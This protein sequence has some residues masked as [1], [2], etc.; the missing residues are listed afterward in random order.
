MSEKGRRLRACNRTAVEVSPVLRIAR[1]T[2]KGG[3][4]AQLG[5]YLKEQIF[6]VKTILVSE[7]L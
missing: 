7:P 3:C 2:T 1:V 5:S 6:I 4:A